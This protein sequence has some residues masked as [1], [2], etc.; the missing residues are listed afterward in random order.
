MSKSEN[1][2]TYYR[3]YHFALPFFIPSC[4]FNSQLTSTVKTEV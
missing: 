3:E 2:P 1:L 4:M